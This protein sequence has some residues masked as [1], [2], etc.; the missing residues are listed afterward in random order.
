MTQTKA[1]KDAA[2]RASKRAELRKSHA[3]TWVAVNPG[4]FIDGVVQEIAAAW[5]DAQYKENDPD[6]GFYPLL[7][8]EVREAPGYEPGQVVAV[9]A[10]AAVL[11]S[12]ILDMEPA[13]TERVTITYDGTGE[14]KVRGRNAPELYRLVV[15]GRDP[16]ETA[17]R[18]YAQLRGKRGRLNPHGPEPEADAPADAS[19]LPQVPPAPPAQDE[20]GF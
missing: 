16:K 5:S 9:H 19:G 17:A 10:F 3:D 6:S 7:R 1:E 11:Q 20:F 15:H 12:R 14:A 8:V 13:P 18:A 2:E 4:D